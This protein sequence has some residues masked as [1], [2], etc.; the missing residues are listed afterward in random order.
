[1]KMQDLYELGLDES[2]ELDLDDLVGLLRDITERNY[3]AEIGEFI[4]E[5][6]EINLD[7][8]S[9]LKKPCMTIYY[10]VSTCDDP[11]TYYAEEWLGPMSGL[12]TYL[13]SYFDIKLYFSRDVILCDLDALYEGHLADIIPYTRSCRLNNEYSTELFELGQLE[14]L[15]LVLGEGLDERDIGKMVEGVLS[16]SN[17]KELEI[18]LSNV[19]CSKEHLRL[20]KESLSPHPEQKLSVKWTDPF[21]LHDE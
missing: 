3:G 8:G 21:D 11:S 12:L 6:R 15:T 17:L 1:M 9:N 10:S 13:E 20:L 18:D 2:Y 7:F 16:M 14:E 4:D 5:I 19:T